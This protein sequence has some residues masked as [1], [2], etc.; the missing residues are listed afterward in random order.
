MPAKH[1]FSIDKHSCLRYHDS[2][3]LKAIV[4]SA[5]LDHHDE[6]ET[7]MHSKNGQSAAPFWDLDRTV[8]LI[9][10]IKIAVTVL[11]F[12]FHGLAPLQPFMVFSFPFLLSASYSFNGGLIYLDSAGVFLVVLLWIAL[13]L[14]SLTGIIKKDPNNERWR[15]VTVVVFSVLNTVDCISYL[16]S[17]F[18]SSTVW[19]W[20]G[21]M[22]SF[23]LV[24]MILAEARGNGR[25][26]KE[27]L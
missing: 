5:D 21:A 10:T 12:I 13:W 14:L 24:L 7:V 20:T 25:T 15:N 1:T 22:I 18:S 11:Y 26:E 3:G 9:C 6:G 2:C 16:I 19:K 17:C 8:L 27:S 4:R 23:C